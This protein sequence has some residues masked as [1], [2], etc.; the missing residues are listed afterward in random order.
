M[1]SPP[2]LIVSEK[3]REL[4]A[5]MW[6][7]DSRSLFGVSYCCAFV[8]GRFVSDVCFFDDEDDFGLVECFDV[9]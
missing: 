9:V 3:W 8:F 2:L 4:S 6:N 1:L 5:L 7:N